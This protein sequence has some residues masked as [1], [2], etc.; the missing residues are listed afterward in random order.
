M[1]LVTFEKDRR[2]RLGAMVAGGILDLASAAERLGTP[3]PASMQALIDAGPKAWDAARALIARCPAE[4]VVSGVRLLAPLPRPVRFRDCS[5]FLE[6][7][8][9]HI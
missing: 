1:R 4:D 8:L 7:S 6:L 5:L 9:I 3:S 2:E